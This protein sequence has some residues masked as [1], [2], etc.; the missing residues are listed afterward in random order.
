[1]RW[2]L[3]L[4]LFM[5]G[6]LRAEAQTDSA[7]VQDELE[8]VFEEF[9]EEALAEEGER[10]AQWL[11][12]L[13]EKPGFEFISR[14]Q[15]V[16]EVPEGYRRPDSAGGYLGSP[17][18]Y[19][20]RMRYRSRNISLN[21]SQEKDAGEAFGRAPA[22]D[23]T[24][25]HL[26]VQDL[27]P[28]RDLVI[29]DYA[30]NFGQGLLAWNGGAFGK[31]REVINGAQRK[32]RGIRPYASAQETD[33]FRGAAI[34]FGRDLQGS[35]FYSNRRRTGSQLNDST[36]RFPT[37]SGLH[38]TQNER[39]RRNNLQ[40][41]TAGGRVSYAQSTF[42]MGVN[43]LLNT[44]NRPVQLSSHNTALA[45]QSRVF[46]TD[47]TFTSGLYHI[48][49]EA[50]VDASR[51]VAV[52]GGQQMDFG[53]TQ[54]I[55]V[56]RKYD[57]DFQS[58]FGNAFGEFSGAPR[59]EEG[60][61]AGIRHQLNGKVSLSAYAD[62]FHH[63]AARFRISQPGRGRD[64]LGLIEIEADPR[65]SFYVLIRHERKSAEYRDEDLLG[66]E[67][68]YIGEQARSSIR[69][70]L[71]KWMTPEFRLR[72]RVEVVRQTDTN[73]SAEFGFLL[74]QDFR[75]QPLSWLKLDGRL[76]FFQTDSF[77]A[78]IYQFEN[79]LRFV[80]TNALLNGEGQRFYLLVNIE[81]GKAG[82]LSVKYAVSRWEDIF[83]VGSGLDRIAGNRRSH[84][85]IQYRL[86]I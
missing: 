29:G 17:H 56:Y 81:T 5:I 3:L 75:W 50:A 24:S 31:G 6:M 30:L 84:I 28:V 42:E 73:E 20:Q 54:A 62:Y 41:I 63:P 67:T 61:Y 16:L 26:A 4:G 86:K 57:P 85:G 18:R 77:D 10:L 43:T 58:F 66:R 70:Q 65:S 2:V 60:F 8:K 72:S 64:Y 80:M 9:D 46:S 38:R 11:L 48:F 13:N 25:V 69:T 21:L 33:F 35:L 79:D 59:N 12:D 15:T 55:M 51:S 36:Y 44:F 27:G 14:V 76:T 1:M 49:G 37:S 32:N 22:F 19:F 68:R 74:F 34:R 47:V 83:E 78:R 23:F 39:A 82:T 7:L 40:Q 53:S 52:I 71:E 45:G